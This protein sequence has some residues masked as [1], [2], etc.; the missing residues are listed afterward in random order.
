MA[1]PTTE[2]AIWEALKAHVQSM[3]L[4]PVIPASRVFLPDMAFTSPGATVS[5][6]KVE[7]IPNRT[8]RPLIDATAHYR[9]IL[10]VSLYAPLGMGLTPSLE[11][12]GDIADHFPADLRLVHSGIGIR[13]V[14][15]PDV[16]PAIREATHLHIPVS[17]DFETYS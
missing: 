2:T 7:H 17:I 15:H 6:F 12:A 4:S 1:T 3:V 5:Y 9:G 10:Q 14:K 11:I 16:G 13:I 8:L